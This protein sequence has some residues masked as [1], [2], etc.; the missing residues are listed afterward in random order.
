VLHPGLAFTVN[1]AVLTLTRDRLAYTQHCF[2]SL[3]DLA[4]HPYHHHVLDQGSEDG[5][6]EWLQAEL[7]AGRLFNVVQRGTNIGCTRGW[8]TLIGQLNLNYYDAVVTFD[9]DCEVLSPSTLRVVA[10]LAATHQTILAPR[11]LGLMYPPP[12]INT[13][14]LGDYTV[15][16]TTILGNIF[17]AIPAVLFSRDRYRWDERYAVWDGGESITQWHRDRGG[18]CGYVQGF[19]VNHYL[20]TQGQAA[21]MPWYG[22]RRVREGGRSM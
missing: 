7:D 3:R 22:E 8:N 2:Q 11:V 10:G 13:F 19:E 16:E 6:Q 14:Q 4:G 12:T 5:T 17:M 18:R 21:D 20:T 1:V 15:D 9:N